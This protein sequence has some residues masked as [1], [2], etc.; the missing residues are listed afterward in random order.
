LAPAIPNEP[1]LKWLD[2][3]ED[4]WSIPLLIVGFAFI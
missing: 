2:G 1:F 4:G 3:I